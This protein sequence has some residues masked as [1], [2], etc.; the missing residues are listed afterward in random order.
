M[1][2]GYAIKVKLPATNGRAALEAGLASIA[3]SEGLELELL[4]LE[5]DAASAREDSEE[6]RLVFGVH[7]AGREAV[8]VPRDKSDSVSSEA[9]ASALAAWFTGPVAYVLDTDDGATR[10]SAWN[11]GASL[12][13]RTG[14]LSFGDSVIEWY[15]E[16]VAPPFTA[17]DGNRA[18]V[19]LSQLEAARPASVREVDAHFTAVSARHAIGPLSDALDDLAVTMTVAGSPL[20]IRARRGS[21][22]ETRTA[23]MERTLRALDS[24]EF[25]ETMQ[26]LEVAADAVL[27]RAVRRQLPRDAHLDSFVRKGPP[28]FSMSRATWLARGVLDGEPFETAVNERLDGPFADDEVPVGKGWWC[29]NRNDLRTTETICERTPDVCN[30]SRRREQGGG[31]A[32]SVCEQRASASSYVVDT[33]PTQAAVLIPVGEKAKMVGCFG[34]DAECH[35]FRDPYAA[36]SSTGGGVV[37]VSTCRTLD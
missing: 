3:L 27:M 22:A 19:F 9:L 34:S 23:V 36:N 13:P 17:L 1:N 14:W 4:T 21:P 20:T 24:F 18:R 31:S 25:P 5:P 2:G 6:P 26:E 15:V 16:F 30:S 32:V 33:D 10:L 28:S 12:T 8:L 11:G 35:A 7:Q 37:A 29:F